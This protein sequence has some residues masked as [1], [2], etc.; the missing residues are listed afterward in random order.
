MQTNEYYPYTKALPT[1]EH[2]SKVFG[3]KIM[4][5]LMHWEGSAP[6]APPYVWPPYG[7]QENYLEFVKGLHGKGNLAGLY[8]SGIGYTI[9]SNNDP[10][11]NM[12]VPSNA[13]IDK[14]DNPA[15]LKTNHQAV[16]EPGV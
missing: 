11:Y 5:L 14:L 15:R 4:A 9:K 12:G 13:N 2:Y 7:G 10:S 3:A 16:T 6:W 8:A 1:L